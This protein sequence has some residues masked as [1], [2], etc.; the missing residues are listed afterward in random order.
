MQSYIVRESNGNEFVID[1]NGFNEACNKLAVALS[2]RNLMY[3][4]DV[5][6]GKEERYFNYKMKD[7]DLTGTMKDRLVI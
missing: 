4:S 3:E 1:A 7:G 5:Y 2:K 6:F